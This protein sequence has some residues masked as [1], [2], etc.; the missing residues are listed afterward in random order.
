MKK[1]KN[2][3]EVEVNYKKFSFLFPIIYSVIT[4]I[5]MLAL[6]LTGNDIVTV[7]KDVS[8]YIQSASLV[9]LALAPSALILCLFL[10]KR[11][12]KR[13]SG[14]P[15]FYTDFPLRFS[16]LVLGLQLIFLAMLTL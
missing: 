3:K 12:Q 11:H 5:I 7:S 10:G 15:K 8:L 2:V 14:A 13:Y 9:S 16:A 6:L 4:I 1:D